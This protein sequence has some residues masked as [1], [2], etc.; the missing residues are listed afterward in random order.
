MPSYQGKPDRIA[1]TYI[2]Q[3]ILGA[4][5]I[6]CIQCTKYMTEMLLNYL[7]LNFVPSVIANV[8]LFNENRKK[9]T[10]QNQFIAP[11]KTKQDRFI[12]CNN[13]IVN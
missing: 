12:F 3:P 13:I 4:E 5:Y 9:V 6:F 10:V 1:S 11:C 7:H 2:L 8:M